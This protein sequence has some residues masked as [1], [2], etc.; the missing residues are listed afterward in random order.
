MRIFKRV[1]ALVLLACMVIPMVPLSAFA[2]YDSTGRP[3]DLKNQLYLA[4][5][6]G[7]DDFPGEPANHATS[8]YNCLNSNFSLGNSS[9]VF[10]TT[11]EEILEPS[12]LDDVV[13]GSDRVWGVFSTSGGSRYLKSSSGL[14]TGED[15]QVNKPHNETTE[16]KIIKNLV[17]GRKITLAQGKTAEDYTIVWYVI[18]FQPSDSAWHIDGKVIEKASYSVNYYGNGNTSGGAPTGTSGLHTNDRY[19][20]LGNTGNLQK[21]IGRDTYLFKGWNTNTD[22]T[23]THYNAGDTIVINDSNVTLYAEWY[24]QNRYSASVIIKLDEVERNI[25]EVHSGAAGVYL[26]KEGSTEYIE[27]EKTSA[28]TYTTEVT[29]NGTY[30]VYFRHADGEF[31]QAHGHSVI[32]YNQNARTEF[33]NYTVNYELG[34]DGYWAEGEDPGVKVYHA[35]SQVIA[36]EN[37]PHRPGYTFLGWVDQNENAVNPGHQ[38]T[39]KILERT[40]LTAQWEKNVNVT[41][42]ITVNHKKGDQLNAEPGKD[43]VLFQLL[44]NLGNVNQPYGEKLYLNWE[45]NDWYQK[46]EST[47]EVTKYSYT[48]QDL[49]KGI[50]TATANKSHYK[51]ESI[52]HEGTK[53][54]DQTINIVL[55]YEPGTFDL[56]F[57]VKAKPVE[58]Q[59]QELMPKAVNV[60]VLVWDATL[61]SWRL[62]DQHAGDSAPVTVYLDDAGNGSGFVPVW[63]Y[64]P[65]DSENLAVYRVIATSFVMPNGHVVHAESTDM[66]NFKSDPVVSGLYSAV[67]TVE[68]GDPSVVQSERCDL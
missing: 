23:G 21:K 20:V 30:M 25:E 6:L 63:Q 11:A 16:Q 47:D 32:I 33:L 24:L 38:V 5:Y 54:T 60:K 66:V 13:E 9:S 19:T 42:N 15:G 36:T 64:M 68:D 7:T 31:E 27:L 67:S 40:V 37:I 55:Q 56:D 14:V 43:E 61:E 49:P 22:G 48:I 57:C 45:N 4:I 8:G 10:A 51:L 65:H 52:T 58:V 46:N 2:A 1:V 17:D 35:N 29:E 59:G 39:D 28:G 41:V 3:L 44:Q 34:E 62:I 12:I 18:K 50:Y 26:L 53:D